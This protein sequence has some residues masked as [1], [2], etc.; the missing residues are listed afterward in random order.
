M[1]SERRRERS[2]AR[3]SAL[4]VFA[5]LLGPGCANFISGDEEAL[6]RFAEFQVHG[7]Q[8]RTPEPPAEGGVLEGV[9]RYRWR[10]FDV[11]LEEVRAPSGR[12]RYTRLESDPELRET[13]R[14]TVEQIA[15]VDPSKL[16]SFEEKLAFWINAYNA[17]VLD[18][19][20]A[21]WAQDPSFRVDTND[22]AFFKEEVHVVGGK[23]YS[24]NQIENGVIRGDRYHPS[25]AFLTDEEIAPIL[26]LHDDLWEGR[27]LDPRVHFALNCASSSCPDLDAEPW[28]PEDLDARLDAVTEAFLLDAGRGAGPDGIS[29]I[30]DFYLLDFDAQHVGGVD[31]FI[32]RYR[33]LDDVDTA[34]FLLYD[35]SLNVADE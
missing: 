33:S 18:G 31:A 34:R 19:A 7:G 21:G 24:L 27:D 10:L 9:T 32:A 17:L 1:R 12:V 15:S 26:A 35:W 11:A 23:T 13:L 20:A 4:A 5:L 29:Q 8:C 3:P 22:F 28:R 16:A 30:F 25:L 2:S 6:D 14:L